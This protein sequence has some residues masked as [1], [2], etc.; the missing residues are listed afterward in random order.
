MY[1]PS[2]D[3]LRL[4]D[5]A[6]H[7]ARLVRIRT[8]LKCRIK[9][10]LQ[11]DGVRYKMGWNKKSLDYLKGLDPKIANFVR[12]LEAIDDE[13]KQVT[14]E[15][16][17]V[18]GNM[19]L[20][21]LLRTIPGIGSFSSLMI[22]GEVGDVKRFKNPK[23]LVSYAGLCPGVHQSGD[24]TRSVVNRACNK[25]LKWVISEC[26]GKASMLDGRYMKHYH[27]VKD[28]KGFKVARRS[29]A[30]KMLIDIWHVRLCKNSF[31]FHPFTS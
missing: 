27:R 25:W 28:R 20:A 16:N 10:Y 22:L 13:I 6:R 24:R 23:S 11:R 7:R 15:I 4:R 30:R 18:A 31:S 17:L 2:K 14:R 9:S 1:I 8:S 3:V 26:S 12:I 29:V 21:N 5:I 19:R